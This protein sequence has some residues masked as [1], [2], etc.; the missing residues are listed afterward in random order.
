[1]PVVF[2]K[3]PFGQPDGCP[4]ILLASDTERLGNT[5]HQVLRE[6]GFEV[7]FAGDYSGLASH[8]NQ[9][10][11]DMVLLEVSGD[12]AVEPAVAAALRVKRR[13]AGQFVGYLADSSLDASGLAG[14]GLFPRSATKL[15]DALRR[16]F[17]DDSSG[18]PALE[19][20]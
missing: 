16:F 10:S 1:M 13:N 20:P 14:D 7:H 6:E 17:S 18:G 15:P 19:K 8:L 3:E 12:Y 5:L 9:R 11:F 2:T 4:S